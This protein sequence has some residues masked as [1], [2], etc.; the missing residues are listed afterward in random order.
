MVPS[1]ESR[2]VVVIGKQM[3]SAR[4]EMHAQVSHCRRAECRRHGLLP[5][6]ALDFVV[7]SQRPDNHRPPVEI[8]ADESINVA[9]AT[10]YLPPRKAGRREAS[11]AVNEEERLPSSG[12][13]QAIAR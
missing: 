11:S 8:Y 13:Y 1:M 12:G 9:E 7:Y 10:C 4:G 2:P 3:R 5:C 6:P